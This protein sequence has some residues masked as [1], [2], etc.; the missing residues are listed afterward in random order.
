MKEEKK[1][2]F[3]RRPCVEDGSSYHGTG[4]LEEIKE[5]KAEG[6]KKGR[7][8]KGRRKEGEDRRRR[9]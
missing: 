4:N 2:R 9:K 7:E 6:N 1:Y 5:V 8:M 3:R